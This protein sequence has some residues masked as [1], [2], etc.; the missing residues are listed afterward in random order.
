MND[1]IFDLD[2]AVIR[3]S[4]TYPNRFGLTLAADLY[5]SK[6]TDLSHQHPALLVGS[7]YGG[8]KE[9][10]PGI[11]AQNM[12]KRG[13]IVVTFDESYN[14]YSGGQPRHISSPDIFVEDFSATVD[15]LGTRPF[16]D[17][18]RIGAIGICGSGSFA[19]SAA[20]IDP[21]I[22]AVVT[23]SM[24]DI[25]ATDA[26]Y[27]PEQKR[28]TQLQIAEQRYVDFETGHPVMGARGY[29]LQWDEKTNPVAREFGEFYATPR[30][31]HPN[32]I[33]Q[34]SWSS[35][36]S[37]MNFNLLDHVDD[38]APRPIM[39]IVGT[40]AFSRSFSDEVYA[41]AAGPKELVEVPGATHIDLYDQCDK[42]PFE[43]INAFFTQNLAK[44]ARRQSSEN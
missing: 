34:F 7:P 20:G 15:F 6:D 3:K 13:F 2:A 8:V 37:F 29:A 9:Q 5:Y 40:A 17:R 18:D 24:I 42:I 32:A 41:K 30:G 26:V 14:G 23:A 33:G 25:S 43:K 12:A 38:I 16:V 36:P 4:V 44:T 21:R 28:A 1:Y 39:L 27:T 19:L 10:G 35:E 31:Y 11:Y 22:K